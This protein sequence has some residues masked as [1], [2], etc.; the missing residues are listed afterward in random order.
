ML[1]IDSYNDG[2]FDPSVPH[3]EPDNP[4]PPPTEEDRQLTSRAPGSELAVVDA[5][6]QRGR[7]AARSQRAAAKADAAGALGSPESNSPPA[8][9]SPA[10]ASSAPASTDAAAAAR[11]S[12][13]PAEPATTPM[14]T[15]EPHAAPPPAAATSGEAGGEGEGEGAAAISGEGGTTVPEEDVTESDLFISEDGEQEEGGGALSSPLT[16]ALT[17]NPRL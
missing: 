13:R 6:W 17:P 9:T 4:E 8:A 3:D 11:G 7:T 2:E 1:T 14:E 5:A 12:P 16:Q 15:D 10:A